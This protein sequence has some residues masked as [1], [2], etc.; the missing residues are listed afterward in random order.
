MLRLPNADDY[1]QLNILLPAADDVIKSATGHDWAA[2]VAIDPTAKML[3][4][5]LVSRW[6]DDPGQVGMQLSPT[7]PLMPLVGQLHAKV[8]QMVMP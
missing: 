8:L 2:D 6:F 5:V 7:D 4:C 3:A 1:P